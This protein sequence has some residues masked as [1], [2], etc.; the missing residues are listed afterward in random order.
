MPKTSIEWCDYSW[1][2][3]NGCR[4]VSPG[5][6]GATGVGGC[7][8]ERLAATRLRHTKRYAGLAV[9]GQNGPR[10]TG[11][12]RLIREELTMP[13]RM[14][15]PSRIFVA[16]MGDLFFEGNSDDDIDT[17]FGVMW[18]GLYI[19]STRLVEGHTFQVLTKR[20]ARMRDYLAG[21]DLPHRWARAAVNVWGGENP[22]PLYD[23]TS[24]RAAAGPHPRIWLGVS[25]EDQQR[26]DERIPLLLETPAAVRFVSYEPAL[27][28]VDFTRLTLVQEK[29]PFGPG[30]Y[31]NALTGHVAGPDDLL[32]TRLDWVIVGGESGSG[33]RPFDVAWARS[34][35][36][37]CRAAGV[38]AFC[39]QLGADVRTRNDDNFTDD[40]EADC[41]PLHLVEEDRIESDVHGFR[42]EHQGAH[43]RVRLRDRKGGD[44]SEWPEDLRVREFPGAR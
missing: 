44:M 18:A 11:E 37:Q 27:G 32:P 14:R 10:W 5:C 23:Q 33:A 21:H 43:V 16:D 6:G 38:A 7:Y 19:G 15:T 24:F 26:A 25:V 31:L 42:E 28:H 20:A 30:V 39:K 8:A 35:I 41:W 1:P 34:T 22:D 2:V 17:V 4:R 9:F 29:P 36:E 40:G 12:S 3:I 13:L